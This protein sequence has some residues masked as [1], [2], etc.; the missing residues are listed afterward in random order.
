MKKMALVIVV[1]IAFCFTTEGQEVISNVTISEAVKLKGPTG[2]IDK[3]IGEY[4]DEV[5][6]L[7][8]QLAARRGPVATIVVYNKMYQVKSK[9]VIKLPRDAEFQ[10]IHLI[11]GNLNVFYMTWNNNVKTLFAAP[12]STTGDL[13]TKGIE[14]C[15]VNA[16]KSKNGKYNTIRSNFFD[17]KG[18]YYTVVHNY[19]SSG[20]IFKLFDVNFKK[21][22][23]VEIPW[24]KGYTNRKL[25]SYGIDE[26]GN[27]QLLINEF[28]LVNGQKKQNN[29]SV[30]SFY[31]QNL[32]YKKYEI[33]ASGEVN[34][35]NLMCLNNHLIISGF[36]S[37]S[38]KSF[39]KKIDL[40]KKE[41]IVD[42]ESNLKTNIPKELLTQAKSKNEVLKNYYYNSRFVYENGESVWFY[43]SYYN[44]SKGRGVDA[45]VKYYSGSLFIIHYDKNGVLKW[46]DCILKKQGSLGGKFG[47]FIGA[48]TYQLSNG[49]IAVLFNDNPKNTNKMNPVKLRSMDKFAKSNTVMFTVNMKGAVNKKV[50]WE[51]KVT[52]SPLDSRGSYLNLSDEVIF[53]S[54]KKDK[55]RVCKFNLH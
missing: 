30:F 8:N 49:L 43:E 14:L 5:F 22:K 20:I 16:A 4:N 47:G 48:E 7:R 23:S 34:L 54:T 42:E 9:N 45:Y 19:E 53:L 32:D 6:V 1:V 55:L 26:K 21:I 27:L 15:N 38:E 13:K 52:K 50:L 18:I 46:T 31:N 25:C 36:S 29:Y 37:K 24:T 44:R 12:L 2:S 11:E 51:N 3:I 33:T 40:Q 10:S 28:N 17:G 39:Y 35:A 41:M